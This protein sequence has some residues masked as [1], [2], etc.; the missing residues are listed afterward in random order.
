MST[1]PLYTVVPALLE[2]LADSQEAAAVDLHG[3]ARA[4]RERISTRELV[5]EKLDALIS[6]SFY[7]GGAA[8]LTM[9]S[10]GLRRIAE[11]LRKDGQEAPLR[12]VAE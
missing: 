5:D 6:A 10:D 7:Q 2:S 12:A 3:H 8:S 1:N 4:A 9:C 11:S